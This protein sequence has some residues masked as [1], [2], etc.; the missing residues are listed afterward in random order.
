MIWWIISGVLFLFGMLIFL[1]KITIDCHYQHQIDDDLLTVQVK[2]WA[3]HIYTFSSPVIKVDPKTLSVT[4]EEKNE[5]PLGTTDKKQRFTINWLKK[6][7]KKSQRFLQ[8]VTGFYKIVQ[9][10]MKK[11]K[12][13]KLEWHSQVGVDDAVLTAQ[14]AGALWT[15]KGV[16]IGFVSNFFTLVHY[17][18]IQVDPIYQGMMT[19][20]NFSCM[21]SFRIGQA[22]IAGLLIV[23]HWHKTK[24]TD[25]QGNAM[26]QSM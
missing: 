5:S 6:E 7:I 14:L 4:L 17:P 22:I 23:K 19:K 13:K 9:R 11:V 2:L 10:F 21:F 25:Q 12:V 15:L 3:I 16:V 18:R 26:D 24:K 1:A 20:T 8:Q